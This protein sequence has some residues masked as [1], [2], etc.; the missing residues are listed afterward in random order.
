MAHT[1]VGIP[2]E[3][4]LSIMPRLSTLYACHQSIAYSTFAIRGLGFAV[5]YSL[6]L[7]RPAKSVITEQDIIVDNRPRKV[8]LFY[9]WH[10]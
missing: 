8:F 1:G 2:V 3:N 4:E 5:E 6:S 7:R 9:P 10:R